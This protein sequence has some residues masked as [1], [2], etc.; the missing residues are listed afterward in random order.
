[1]LPQENFVDRRICVYEEIEQ[2][3]EDNDDGTFATSS[4]QRSHQQ[5]SSS[6]VNSSMVGQSTSVNSVAR[7]YV[8]ELIQSVSFVNG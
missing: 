6:V 2:E 1:M 8:G 7:A 3:S 4:R 5:H